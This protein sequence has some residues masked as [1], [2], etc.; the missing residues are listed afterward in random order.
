M[1]GE[2]QGKYYTLF[3]SS[4]NKF[5]ATILDGYK[6]RKVF[7]DKIIRD[8]IFGF[9]IFYK[10]E[11]NVIDSPVMQRLRRIRQTSLAFHTY[12]SATHSRFEHSLNCVGLAEKVLESVARK[13]PEFA[14]KG[15]PTWAEV[16]LAALLHDCGHG[17][18]S[19]ASEEF[20]EEFDEFERLKDENPSLFKRAQPHEIL[21]YFIVKSKPFKEL[22]WRPIIR[23]Y[24]SKDGRFCD[25][26]AVKFDRVALMIIG[27]EHPDKPEHKY[28][29]QIVNG[30][31]DIDKLDYLLR[32]G[33]FTGLQ[34]HWS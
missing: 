22:L 5:V 16:R 9:N 20:L 24:T 4:I 11:I 26:S 21:S 18:F 15:T 31:F 29:T 30:P 25:L 12:P 14:R 3:E 7:D 33:Y 2:K 34:V 1:G 27:K 23:L 13:K 28:L 17:P 32:D 19:H 10:H 8:A 6:P